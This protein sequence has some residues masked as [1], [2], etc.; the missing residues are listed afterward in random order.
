MVKARDDQPDTSSF[1]CRKH[2]RGSDDP[3]LEQCGSDT[4]PL[5]RD[6]L[7]LRASCDARTSRKSERRVGRVRLR[8]TCP[9][10]GPSA[11]SVP[12]YGGGRGS[13]DPTSFPYAFGIRGCEF[14]AYYGDGMSAYP[15]NEH[16][17]QR[18]EER[19]GQRFWEKNCKSIQ[20][21]KIDQARLH[22]RWSCSD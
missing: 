19:A 20:G 11:A 3:N 1:P 13:Y 14:G 9:G 21:L 15:W 8:R 17:L 6:T 2:V 16:S 10:C 5:L 12:S 18:S 22:R 7:Q 4:L